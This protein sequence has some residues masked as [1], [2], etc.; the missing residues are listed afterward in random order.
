M[1]DKQA[2]GIEEQE[3]M[4]RAVGLMVQEC[5]VVKSRKAVVRIED[6]LTAPGS[7]GVFPLQGSVY[8]RRYISGAFVGQYLF[9]LRYRVRPGG[10]ESK[11]I[12]ADAL[13][14]IGRWIEGAAVTVNNTE[15]QLSEYPG[16]TEGRTIDS[17]ERQTN[18]F[19]AAL[20]EDGTADYQIN[21]KVTYSRKRG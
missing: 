14:Q 17:I 9:M 11:I 5:P 12:A 21:L 10:D 15:Y 8:L 3:A 16:L 20:T 19:L 2:L 13:D 1:A 4:T 7:I 6:I 18:A